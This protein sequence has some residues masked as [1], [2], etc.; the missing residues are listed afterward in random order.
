MIV[1]AGALRREKNP[2]RLLRAF[3]PLKD[4]AVLLLV[5]DGP[6][7]SAV[8]EEAAGLKL[9]RHLH[10]L[11]RRTDTRDIIARSQVL[12]LSSDT[13]QMP[14]VVLEAM[15]AGLP[16]VATDVGDIW[17]MV[18]GPN[19]EFIVP[20]GERALSEALD[21]L[22]RNPALRV[23]IG[24]ANRMRQ[25]DLYTLPQMVDAY[26]AVFEGMSTSVRARLR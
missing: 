6:E 4:R 15:E 14:F 21:T 3:A 23:R 1:W 5:G 12:V 22:V 9:G 16:V 13:E 26:S 24:R 18:A 10:L 8:L 7:R 19:R 25:R 2:L 17:D 11:G 20:L